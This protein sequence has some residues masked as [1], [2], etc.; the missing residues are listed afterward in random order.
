MRAGS[1]AAVVA[2]LPNVGFSPV[3]AGGSVE[4]RRWA[5]TCRSGCKKVAGSWPPGQMQLVPIRPR[6]R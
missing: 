2:M 4:Y 5:I 6:P 3:S 1:K